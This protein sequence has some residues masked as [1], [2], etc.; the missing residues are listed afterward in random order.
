MTRIP[1]FNPRSLRLASLAALALAWTA[2]AGAQDHDSNNFGDEIAINGQGDF[3]VVADDSDFALRKGNVYVG[4]GGSGPLTRLDRSA[5]HSAACGSCSDGEFQEEWRGKVFFNGKTLYVTTEEDIRNDN[6]EK[7]EVSEWQVCQG[8]NPVNTDNF[9]VDVGM[10]P[11]QEWE[12]HYV[13]SSGILITS[14]SFSFGTE[15]FYAQKL[16]GDGDPATTLT[17]D[18][19]NRGSMSFSRFSEAAPDSRVGDRIAIFYDNGSTSP[20]QIDV[21]DFSDPANITVEG[22]ISGAEDTPI[23]DGLRIMDVGLFDD[24]MVSL[25]S[26]DDGVMYYERQGG[27]WPAD[28]FAPGATLL[29]QPLEEDILDIAGADLDCLAGVDFN[30]EKVIMTDADTFVAMDFDSTGSQFG[31]GVCFAV[32]NVDLNPVADDGS[33]PLA[34]VPEEGLAVLD[35]V[36][37]AE[38]PNAEPSATNLFSFDMNATTAIMGWASAS[39]DIDTGA[40]PET[41]FSAG[42]IG[43]YDISSMPFP[44]GSDLD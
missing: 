3:A 30:T 23:G 12:Q 15:R 31:D 39:P 6:G 36:F 7:M 22:T 20:G 4:C 28:N 33:D 27:S 32:W 38:D 29:K 43:L 9:T 10:D 44:G 19:S 13:T 2:P 1:L 26:S 18:T 25:F 8:G 41:K 35:R 24:R 11:D 16:I 34:G 37:L 21:V 5:P 40:G 17:L 14:E 42:V